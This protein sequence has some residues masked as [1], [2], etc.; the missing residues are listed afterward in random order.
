MPKF[1][2]VK[3]YTNLR[4]KVRPQMLNIKKNNNLLRIFISWDILQ[5]CVNLVL[6]MHSNYLKDWNIKEN[7]LQNFIYFNQK[8]PLEYLL[9]KCIHDKD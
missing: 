3:I 6:Q 5:K 1:S 7:D 4:F 9:Y 2:P 8:A